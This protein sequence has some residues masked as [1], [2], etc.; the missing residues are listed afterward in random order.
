MNVE[1]LLQQIAGAPLAIQFSDV[2]ATIDNNYTFT[3][4]AF[5]NGEIRNEAGQN[6]GSC[7]IF[8]FARLH[9]LNEEHTLACFGDYYRKDV[10]ASP[11]G[12]DHSN[13]RNFMTSGWSG[14]DFDG[15]ALS[16]K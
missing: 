7:K 9:G 4:T 3:P 8:A 1:H 16:P 14:I 5:S 10:L 15:E 2:I 6:N 11:G 13:I 12:S